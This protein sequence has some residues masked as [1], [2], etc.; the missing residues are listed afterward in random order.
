VEAYVLPQLSLQIPVTNL[1]EI[2]LSDVILSSLADPQFDKSD[3]ID[4]ILGADI[5]GRLLCEG[6][7]RIPETQLILQNTV[8]G[9]IV[10]GS[11]SFNSQRRAATQSEAPLRALY[12]SS[13]SKLIE[14]L[15]N[16]L[17]LEEVSAPRRNLHLPNC[18]PRNLS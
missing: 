6:I 9:W 7:K 1:V 16:F 4:I 14:V 10:S 8:L 18:R 12:C 15:N 3:S 11:I 2:S 13:E 17:K 5:Y